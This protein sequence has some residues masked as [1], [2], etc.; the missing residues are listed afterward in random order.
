MSDDIIKNIKISIKG[1]GKIIILLKN[2][3]KS[4]NLKNIRNKN[5]KITS[6][7][8][9]CDGE[10]V[11]EFDLEPDYEIGDL[12][13]SEDKIYIKSASKLN[14]ENIY[15]YN[16]FWLFRKKSRFIW[17]W[18]KLIQKIFDQELPPEKIFDSLCIQSNLE[19]QEIIKKYYFSLK[20]PIKPFPQNTKKLVV[21]T[22]QA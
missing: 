2:I 4:E 12:V 18:K 15:S 13:D 7:Y 8:Q 19:K 17:E 11:I 22:G 10:D 1:E 5:D 20:K 3:V 16:C 6:E 21:K 14:N 9:F